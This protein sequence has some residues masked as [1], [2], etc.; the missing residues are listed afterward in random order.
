MRSI[1][2]KLI[3]E[4][5]VRDF[6]KSLD[7]C[8]RL[9]EFS[10]AYDRPEEHFAMLDKDGAMIMIEL[11]E[12]GD[13]WLAG[14]MEYPLGQGINFQIEVTDVQKVYDNLK[15]DEYPIF[16]EMEETWYRKDD[17]QVGN[18]QFLVQ[19]P[20]GY[21]LRFFEALGSRPVVS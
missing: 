14:K 2:T 21:V 9:V 4:F 5:K 6:E 8:T 3:P 18:K 20:D 7:F 1:A 11:L 17:T 10:V 19:D 15:K 13:R 16:D 12:A